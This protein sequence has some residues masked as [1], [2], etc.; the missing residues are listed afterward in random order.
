MQDFDSAYHHIPDV[1]TANAL[2]IDWNSIDW[3]GT[4]GNVGP[5]YASVDANPSPDSGDYATGTAD[6][7]DPCTVY[8]SDPY[9]SGSYIW[10]TGNQHCSGSNVVKFVTTVCLQYNHSFLWLFHEWSNLECE[11]ATN[12]GSGYSPNLQ[13]EWPC[14]SGSHVYR[15][16][17]FGN[18][19]DGAATGAVQS[20]NYHRFSC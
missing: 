16:V 18:L 20:Q 4:P 7:S 1:D 19:N 13:P 15:I 10:G 3:C 6:Y 5:E 14:V 17:T 11:P 2:G 8:A 9:E 12:L